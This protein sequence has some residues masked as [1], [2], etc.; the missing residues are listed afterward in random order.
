M[1]TIISL[2][3]IFCAAAL[4]VS[5]SVKEDAAS[6]EWTTYEISADCVEVKTALNGRDVVWEEGDLVACFC[7]N[8]ASDRYSLSF[9][10]APMSISGSNAVFEVTNTS[11][12]MPKILMYPSSSNYRIS[13]DKAI[14]LD[15][16][17]VMPVKTGNAPSEGLVSIGVINE[18]QVQMRNVMALLKFSIESDDICRI[19]ITA[20]GGEP[21]S[22]DIAV[23]LESLQVAGGGKNYVAAIPAEEQEAFAP[24]IYYVP[25]PA[26]EYSKGL[27][28]RFEKTNGDAAKK[29]YAQSY[30]VR[31][32]R[33]VNMGQE[34]EWGL[35]F[36]PG[37][38]TKDIVFSVKNAD[39]TFVD[40]FPFSDKADAQTPVTKPDNNFVRTV[41]GKGEFGPYYLVGWPDMPFYFQVHNTSGY[42]SFFISSGKYGLRLGG[43]K[44]DYMTLPVP[45][46][47]RLTSIY[48]ETGDYTT[49][50]A[51]TNVPE[52][53]GS[54]PEYLVQRIQINKN[55]SKTFEFDA[56]K[57]KVGKPYRIIVAIDERPTA[58]KKIT[59]TYKN[60][61]E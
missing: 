14:T 18:G 19:D 10:I 33:F 24:G 54:E 58:I 15:V 20:P 13:Q 27:S 56:T 41:A 26:N 43:T 25:V 9:D 3:S 1:K 37:T 32:N 12:F 36:K 31:R 42:K 51:V 6:P 22:G 29:A 57:T 5:C 23:N 53:D 11:G 35:V 2:G 48:I 46:G 50:Y 52:D 7:H 44:G 4:T 16:P 34:T 40:F 59:L 61:E 49:S 21:L 38:M 45:A 17:D 28:V 39:G 55:T 60:E 30:T 47:Y 8:E